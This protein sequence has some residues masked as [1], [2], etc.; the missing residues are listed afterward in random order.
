MQLTFAEFCAA[1]WRARL[2][3]VVVVAAAMAAAYA[4]LRVQTRMYQS[5]DTVQLTGPDLSVLSHV[6]AITAVYAEALQSQQTAAAAQRAV[7]GPLGQITARTFPGSPV[8]KVD[9]QSTS[10]VLAAQSAAAVVDA[11]NAQSHTGQYGYPGVRL[12]EIQPPVVPTAP[13]SPRPALT[14][15]VAAVGG[16]G[17]GVVLALVIEAVRRRRQAA[18][19]AGAPALAGRTWSIDERRHLEYEID[20]ALQPLHSALD[21]VRGGRL[22]RTASQRGRDDDDDELSDGASGRTRPG[23][24]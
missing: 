19:A 6:D 11:V 17:V 20:A 8:V 5:T 22:R 18:A 16:V 4:T 13:V 15:G 2:V 9:A 12:L 3:M 24:H 10:P 1:L 7:R 14:Y 23:S 21:R